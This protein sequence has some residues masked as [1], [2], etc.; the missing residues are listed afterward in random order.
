MSDFWGLGSMVNAAANV[1]LGIANI[2]AGIASDKRNIAF[3]RET[4]A[5]NERLTRESW[6]R[7]DNAVQRRVKDLEAAG[8]SP[9][10]AAGP[11][12]GNSNPLP[13]KPPHDDATRVEQ[14]AALMTVMQQQ[15]DYAVTMSQKRLLD[16]QYKKDEESLRHDSVSNLFD[17]SQYGMKRDQSRINYDLDNQTYVQKLATNPKELANLDL[18]I[19]QRK[20]DLIVEQEKYV[21]DMEN[22]YLEKERKLYEMEQLKYNADWYKNHGAPTG[23]N[24]NFTS[25]LHHIGHNIGSGIYD[26]VDKYRE[27][28]RKDEAYKRWIQAQKEQSKASGK[29]G[30]G[31]R[32]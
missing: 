20:A 9:P 31:G 21:R 13:M 4:N 15:A 22:H 25:S 29:G 19:R 3:G 16:L 32:K 26:M 23:Y 10:L 2:G 11:P 30:F 7:D 6:M 18:E 5:Q 8:L 27:K 24:F 28:A 17:E 1:G 14:S 12:A